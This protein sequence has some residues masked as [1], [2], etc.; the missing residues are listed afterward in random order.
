MYHLSAGSHQQAGLKNWGYA[1][2]LQ[3]RLQE[4][5][6]DINMLMYLASEQPALSVI[7]LLHLDTSAKQ[8]S[9]Q[10]TE[11]ISLNVVI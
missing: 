5:F 3:V 2:R 7:Y 10:H 6:F 4:A 1:L 8:V 11:R 9:F